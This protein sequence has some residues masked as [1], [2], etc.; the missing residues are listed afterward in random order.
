VNLFFEGYRD[1]ALD[2][3]A[4]WRA[5]GGQRRLFTS[6]FFHLAVLAAILCAR[7]WLTP[8]WSD[9][10]LTV[11]PS[12]LG[13]ALAA[14][15]LLLAFG[16]EGFREFMAV[17]APSRRDPAVKTSR[18]LAVSAT[19]LHFV[20]IQVIALGFAVLGRS[21]VLGRVQSIAHHLGHSGFFSLPAWYIVRD[22]FAFVSFTAFTLAI[23]MSLAA[24]LAI[25]HTTQ[26]YVAYKSELAQSR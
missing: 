25:F 23:T 13:F 5:Y 16:D 15:A 11:L 3:R 7:E 19:F 2:I 12:L 24:A 9:L 18:S 14:Y 17:P 6:P 10:P 21:H 1:A 26:W 8:A 4:Y 20:I 22:V